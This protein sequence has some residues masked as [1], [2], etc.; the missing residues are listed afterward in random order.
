MI[1]INIKINLDTNI[2]LA[3]FVIDKLIYNLI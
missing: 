1:F 2:F 3:I